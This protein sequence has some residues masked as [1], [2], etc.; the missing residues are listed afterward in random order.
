[1][2]ATEVLA[3]RLHTTGLRTAPAECPGRCP[4]PYCPPSR[5]QCPAPYAA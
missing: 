1:M 5:R 2:S 4:A 3:P